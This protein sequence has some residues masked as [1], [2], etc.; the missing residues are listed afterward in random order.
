MTAGRPESV[1]PGTAEIPLSQGLVALVDAEDAARVVA[2]GKWHVRVQSRTTYANRN[3]RRDDGRWTTLNM[4]TFITGW[5]RVDHINGNGLDN[6]R[7]NLRPATHA[8]NQRN[9]GLQSNNTSGF[10]GVCWDAPRGRWHAKICL[11][12]RTIF[13]GRFDE[14]E[15]AARAYD[16]AAVRYFGEFARLNFRNES[17]V[18]A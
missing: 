8:Q 10:K 6:R 4:H 2:A 13:L 15:E 7:A 5:P 1:R 16:A 9:K 17:A 14:A 3:I 18:A 11:N 12:G